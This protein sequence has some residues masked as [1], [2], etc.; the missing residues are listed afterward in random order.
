MVALPNPTP[1]C[2]LLRVTLP[3]VD[4]KVFCGV[5]NWSAPA[6]LVVGEEPEIARLPESLVTDEPL[7][8]MPDVIK[9]VSDVESPVIVIEP[10]PVNNVAVVTLT[11]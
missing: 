3:L 4:P 8:R 10:E 2:G 11:P 6:L 7:N 5:A 1:V 9:L